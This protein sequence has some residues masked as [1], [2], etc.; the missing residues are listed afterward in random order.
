MAG[1]ATLNLHNFMLECEGTTLLG[2]T[3]KTDR[4]LRRRRSDL[5]CRNGAVRIVAIA[6]LDQALVHTVV[7]RHVKLR[8]LLSVAGVAQLGLLLSQQEFR[9]NRMVRRMA[10]GAT[11]V[12]FRMYGIYGVHVLRARGMA[13]QAPSVDFLGGVIFENKNLVPV[14]GVSEVGKSG[15]VT[16]LA[17]LM[18]RA[19]LS[20]EARLPMRRFF[21]VLIDVFVTGLTHLSP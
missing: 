19:S 13:C 14:A 18:G 1:F 5:L 9:I 21:P 20:V 8:L 11:N 4:V 3:R 15:T 16:A 2:V 7:K 10:G 17:A 12:I 6:A